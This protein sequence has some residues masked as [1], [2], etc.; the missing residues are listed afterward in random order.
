MGAAPITPRCR[1]CEKTWNRW[2]NT[3]RTKPSD[4]FYRPGR[5]G[6]R[7]E[8]TGRLKGFRRS[9][10]G[11]TTPA[12]VKCLDCGHVWWSVHPQLVRKAMK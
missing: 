4:R 8:V 10:Q 5:P 2:W 9:S 11:S 6:F 7:L 1:K 3:F 12:E